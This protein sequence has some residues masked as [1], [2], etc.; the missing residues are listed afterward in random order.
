MYAVAVTLFKVPIKALTDSSTLR[1]IVKVISPITQK[2]NL[3]TV[4]MTE[5]P[6][7]GPI[8]TCLKAKHTKIL[9]KK[10]DIVI[11]NYISTAW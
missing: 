2:A 8:N 1:P 3:Q 10:P 7:N 6:M 4:T 9:M 5:F 11:L